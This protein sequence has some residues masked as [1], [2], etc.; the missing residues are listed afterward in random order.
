M[1]RERLKKKRVKV[2]LPTSKEE[3]LPTLKEEISK[4]MRHLNKDLPDCAGRVHKISFQLEKI[5]AQ[6][7][8]QNKGDKESKE[9]AH[10]FFKRPPHILLTHLGTNLSK[11]I[12]L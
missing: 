12:S 7:K 9:N 2:A 1:L 5:N 8:F 3:N 11:T 4:A 6:T 10:D